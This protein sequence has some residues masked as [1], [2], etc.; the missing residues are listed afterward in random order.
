MSILFCWN[1]LGV[2][3]WCRIHINYVRLPY[4]ISY[5]NLNAYSFSKLRVFKGMEKH[6]PYV[7]GIPSELNRPYRLLIF[8]VRSQFRGL[9]FEG[10]I[11]LVVLLNFDQSL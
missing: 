3:C 2:H 10:V 9:V 11:S 1:I 6:V 7:F 8:Q 5:C 4:L